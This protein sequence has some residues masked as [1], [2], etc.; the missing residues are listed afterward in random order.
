VYLIGRNEDIVLLTAARSVGVWP[1]KP[2]SVAMQIQPA[3]QQPVTPST[4]IFLICNGRAC[5]SWYILRCGWQSPG[6]FTGPYQLTACDHSR[7]LLHQ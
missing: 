5:F 6:I 1:H 2:K 3:T 7:Q 4:S